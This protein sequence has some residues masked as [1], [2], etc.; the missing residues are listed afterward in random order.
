MAT[1]SLG[2]LTIDLIAKIGGLE[3][4]LSKADR[5]TRAAMRTIETSVNR[6]SATVTRAFAVATT[7]LTGFG[8]MAVKRLVDTNK[9]LY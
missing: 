4:G 1:R 3:E 6:F 7:A 9:E 8:A 2:V 5:K